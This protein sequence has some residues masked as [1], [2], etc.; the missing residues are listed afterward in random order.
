MPDL[1]PVKLKSGGGAK[2]CRKAAAEHMKQEKFAI[3]YAILRL[4]RVK[5][6]IVCKLPLGIMCCSSS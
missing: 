2:N 6:K 5:S 3:S 4:E 1:E